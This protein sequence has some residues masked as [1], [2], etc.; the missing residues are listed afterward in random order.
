MLL[1]LSWILYS[2]KFPEKFKCSITGKNKYTCSDGKHQIDWLIENDQLETQFL[3]GEKQKVVFSAFSKGEKFFGR[4][5]LEVF[6]KVHDTWKPQFGL[7][8]FTKECF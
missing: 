6:N 5:K 3:L 2:Q 4:N 8:L 1:R 7:E